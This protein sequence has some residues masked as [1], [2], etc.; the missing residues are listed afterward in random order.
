MNEQSTKRRKA[1]SAAVF[2]N[3]LE[4]YDF[5]V[6]S[7]VATIIARNFFP[8]GDD[9]AAL[10]ATFAVFG[11]GF[12]IR[13]LGAIVIGRIGDVKGRKVA[14]LITI[15]LMALGTTMIALIPASASRLHCS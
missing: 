15:M 3:M 11:V 6:Y 7:Y 1:L 10:L 13:P 12:V 14:M 4:W 5:A 9:V 8:P 2:G